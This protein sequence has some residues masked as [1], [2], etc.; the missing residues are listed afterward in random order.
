MATNGLDIITQYGLSD[1]YAQCVSS[2][3]SRPLLMFQL[4]R[5]TEYKNANF[6]FDSALNK[7]CQILKDLFF[8]VTLS[9]CFFYLS[10]SISILSLSFFL[11][12]FIFLSLFFFIRVFIHFFSLSVFFCLFSSL[13]LSLSLSRSFCFYAFHLSPSLILHPK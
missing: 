1:H 13:S 3:V 5:F 11:F 7:I 2:V 4:K 8:C 6:N 9:N 10:F 12:S